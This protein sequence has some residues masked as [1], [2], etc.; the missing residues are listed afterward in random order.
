[1]LSQPAGPL[2]TRSCQLAFALARTWTLLLAEG[3]RTK[4]ACRAH[5]QAAMPMLTALPC[6]IADSV[7]QWTQQEL[8]PYVAT[9]PA[10]QPAFEELAALL[11]SR[12]FK[13]PCGPQAI[14]MLKA[15]DPM[16]AAQLETFGL[17]LDGYFGTLISDVRSPELHRRWIYCRS[18]LQS[19]HQSAR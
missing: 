15:E 2:L 13:L 4:S 1:M 14:Q 7:S 12:P 5:A 16:A 19:L 3:C 9:L 11:R 17:D 18:M 8:E 6:V 10:Q